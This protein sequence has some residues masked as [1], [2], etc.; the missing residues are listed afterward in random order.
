[1]GGKFL[2][3]NEQNIIALTIYSLHGDIYIFVLRYI[4]INDNYY[5]QNVW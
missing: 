4:L 3:W 5:F 1:M 2:T